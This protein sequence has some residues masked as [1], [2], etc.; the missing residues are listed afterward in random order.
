VCAEQD[1]LG[2]TVG[3]LRFEN[4]A[5]KTI[6]CE[7]SAAFLLRGLKIS[8]RQGDLMISGEF[9]TASSAG[10]P[11]FISVRCH[12]CAAELKGV[13][14][15]LGLFL[16]KTLFNWDSAWLGDFR[17]ENCRSSGRSVVATLKLEAGS[18]V[19]RLEGVSYRVGHSQPP[20]PAPA[21]LDLDEAPPS[22]LAQGQ[23]FAAKFLWRNE[24]TNRVVQS[25]SRDYCSN[26]QGK[27]ALRPIYWVDSQLFQETDSSNTAP[28]LRTTASTA[29]FGRTDR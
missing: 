13:D 29:S 12:G 26:P 7:G 10:R 18:S 2:K 15:A 25:L 1:L 24:Y 20:K 17:I 27:L 19:Q 11:S 16:N 22:D 6:D 8:S 4:L 28:Y 3:S 14:H 9:S 23:S 21:F 5:V